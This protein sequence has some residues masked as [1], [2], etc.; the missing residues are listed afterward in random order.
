MLDIVPASSRVISRIGCIVWIGCGIIVGGLLIAAMKY[1]TEW[2]DEMFREAP[3]VQ[4][5]RPSP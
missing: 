4:P 1:C 2:S 3:H 5:A